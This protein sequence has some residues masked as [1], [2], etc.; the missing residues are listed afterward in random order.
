MKTGP[1]GGGRQS[2]YL[3]AVRRHDLVV[4]GAGTGNALIDDRFADPDPD[5]YPGDLRITLDGGTV[6]AADTLLIAVGRRP[7]SD[8]LGGCRRHRDR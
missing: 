1:R 4:L 6:Q 7:N 3:P 5:V 2:G 8:R